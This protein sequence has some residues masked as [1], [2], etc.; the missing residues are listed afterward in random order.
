MNEILG[1]F[2]IDIDR[3]VFLSMLW[4][5]QKNNLF[6]NENNFVHKEDLF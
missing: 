3:A 6:V 1:K 2:T 5:L 4:V